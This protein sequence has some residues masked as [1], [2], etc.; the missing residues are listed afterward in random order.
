M[1]VS[2]SL[3]EQVDSAASDATGGAL[4]RVSADKVGRLMDLVGEV[5]L[6]VSEIIRPPDLVGLKL[7]YFEKS[8][9]LLRIVV[10][11]VQEAAAELRHVPVGDVFRRM[12]RMV[13]ELERTTGKE[14]DL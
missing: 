7:T 9:L 12:R 1:S 5:S 13:R 4:L 2:A 6:T 3:A 10:R 14:I 11:D 8:A